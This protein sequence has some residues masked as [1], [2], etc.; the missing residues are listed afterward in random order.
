[1][2]T[3]LILL[4]FVL[5]L[6]RI[7]YNIH[8]CDRVELDAKIRPHLDLDMVFFVLP[9]NQLRRYIEIKN[10]TTIVLGIPSQCYL[11]KN[12]TNKN[13]NSVAS[14]VMIQMTAKMGGVPW[15]IKLPLKVNNL[16]FMFIYV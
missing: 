3:K 8:K 2:K 10:Y 6:F 5:L 15:S 13:L 4:S 16:F 1:L 9:N 7:E 12:L 14:K 11:S